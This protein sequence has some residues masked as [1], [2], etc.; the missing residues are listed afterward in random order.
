MKITNI[1]ILGIAVVAITQI[2]IAV[3]PQTAPLQWAINIIVGAGLGIVIYY[4]QLG[5]GMT[6]FEIIAAIIASIP[7]TYGTNYA[8]KTM[9]IINT[10]QPQLPGIGG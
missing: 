9:G 4:F 5:D 8:L 7:T 2:F 6:L 3:Y 10:I 1:A